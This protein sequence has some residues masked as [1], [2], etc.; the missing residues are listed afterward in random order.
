MVIDDER[1]LCNMVKQHLEHSGAYEVHTAYSGEEGLKQV[2]AKTFDLVIT[3]FEM[4]GMNGAEV[5]DA[6]KKTFPDLPVLLFSIYHDVEAVI[7][8]A[9]YRSIAGVIG[10]PFDRDQLCRAIDNI[11]TQ[12]QKNL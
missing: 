5:I 11:L 2:E 12:R 1:K 4:P 9:L 7:P 3:D 8:S 6:L 10:K